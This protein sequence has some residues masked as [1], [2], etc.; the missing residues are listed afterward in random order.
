M[1]FICTNNCLLSFQVK[2]FLMKRVLIMYLFSKVRWCGVVCARLLLGL[3]SN[4]LVYVCSHC[5]H[6]G[7]LLLFQ[8]PEASSQ[9]LF[10]DS[11]AHI[12]A[13]EGGK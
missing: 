12:W 7:E 4:S 2:Q 8:L 5:V 3:F 13:L 11:Q 9:A 10:A 1:P 6:V